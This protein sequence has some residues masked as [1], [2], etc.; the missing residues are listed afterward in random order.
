MSIERTIT[1]PNPTIS[2][3]IPTIPTNSHEEV[4]AHLKSQTI[5]NFEVIVVNNANLDICEARNA[6]IEAADSNI[7]ALTD[8]DCRPETDWLSNVVTEFNSDPNLVCLEGRVEGGRTYEGTRKYV[9]CNLAFNRSAALAVGG[10]SSRYAGWRDD[11]EFGWRMEREA[12]GMCLYSDSV[13]MHHPDLP[14]ANINTELEAQLKAEYPNRYE[15]VIAPDTT[16]GQI[17]DWLWRK[18]FWDLA[19][20]IRYRN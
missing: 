15:N 3:V 16:I 19:D 13:R 11:T 5:D 2:V 6:G 17:N 1:A 4:V 18:G 14:R 12:N 8:D 9:G 20:A 7:V 10:F